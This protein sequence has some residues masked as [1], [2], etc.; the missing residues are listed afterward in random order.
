VISFSDA[1]Y[2]LQEQYRDSSRLDARLALHERFGTNPHGWH[3]WLFDQLA[4]A[5]RERVLEAGC[6]SGALWLKNVD[7]LPGASMLL[8]DF[9]PGMAGDARQALAPHGLRMRFAVADAQSL[10]FRSASFDVVVANHML[11]HVPDV[12]RA[13]AELRRVLRPAG[14]LFAATNGRAHLIQ[15]FD[16][17]GHDEPDRFGLESGEPILRRYF[18]S[19]EVRRYP[20]G[21][22]ITDAQPVI[23]YIASMVRERPLDEAGRAAV[24]A[25]VERAIEREGAFRVVK[26]AGVLIATP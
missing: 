19:V 25:Y 5:E 8:S 18:S 14:R 3:R 6:G 24:R 11:Y 9:S 26:D 4:L 23:D 17:A 13:V 12:E 7:R 21:L 1:T 2:L 15:L 10:P 16:L 20:D 22:A